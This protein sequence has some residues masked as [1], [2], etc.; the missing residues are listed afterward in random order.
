[1]YFHYHNTTQLLVTSIG[2]LLF[3]INF[4]KSYMSI[5]VSNQ[6]EIKKVINYKV[7]DL[8]EYFNFDI[9]LACI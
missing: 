5:S 2:M 7:V 8:I 6:S 3:C 9:N 4:S 1:M